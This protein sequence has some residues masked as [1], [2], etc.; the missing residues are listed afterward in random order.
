MYILTIT[1]VHK[2]NLK[3][4]WCIIVQNLSKMNI[5]VHV[6]VIKEPGEDLGGDFH[7]AE[8]KHI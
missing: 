3:S 7:N 8:K 6:L 1:F 4:F 5:N 2:L